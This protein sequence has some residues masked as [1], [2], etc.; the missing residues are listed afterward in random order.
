MASEDITKLAESLAKTQVGRGLLSFKGKSLK[1]NTAE[2]AEDVVKEIEEF[3]GLEALRFEGNTVRVEAAKAIAK[4][5]EKKSQ[6]KRCHWS[7]MFTGR[8]RSEIP[9]LWYISL[10]EALISAGCQLVELDLSDNAFGPDGVSGFEALLKSPTCFT[11]QELKLNNCGM[12]IGGGKILAGALKECHR[13]STAQGKPLA[14][15]VFM[16]GRN[17]L[18][19]DGATALAEAFTVSMRIRV[20]SH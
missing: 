4:A 1:L 16:A 7:D 10:G 8:L 6:L 17:H 19:N 5:L 11:L 20:V 3:D 12:G 15:K 2:D 18:E 9:L 13:K 14:L